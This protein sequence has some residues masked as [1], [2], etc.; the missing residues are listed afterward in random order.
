MHRLHCLL[1]TFPAC[2]ALSSHSEPATTVNARGD[3]QVDLLGA[4]DP[5]ITPTGVAGGSPLTT[6]LTVW[7]CTDLYTVQRAWQS[8]IAAQTATK[9]VCCGVG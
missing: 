3:V 9:L 7:T 8:K 4:P 6:A 1:L 5:A 2:T